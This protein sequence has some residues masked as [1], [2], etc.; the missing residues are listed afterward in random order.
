M[1]RKYIVRLQSD[2][3]SYLQTIIRK[4]K[5]NAYRIRHA[6]ILLAVAVNGSNMSDQEAAKAFGCHG[7]TVENIRQRFVAQGFEAALER[8]QRDCPARKRLLD[9]DGEALLDF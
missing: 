6:N 4:G 8:R 9:G 2:E 7:R 3:K 1:T 5:T